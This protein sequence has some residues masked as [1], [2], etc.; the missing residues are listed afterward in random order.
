MTAPPP[1]RLTQRLSA[2]FVRTAEPGFYCDGHGLNL[3]VDP[4][5][6]R[7]AKFT[8]EWAD[9]AYEKSEA[10]ADSD[11]FDQP[12]VNS[13]GSSTGG[14]SMLNSSQILCQVAGSNRHGENHSTARGRPLPRTGGVWSMESPAQLV[15]FRRRKLSF[16][17][18]V[19]LPSFTDRLGSVSKLS[20]SI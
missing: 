15:S 13:L 16:A 3:R 9:A 11:D 18:V 5:G 14:Q 10:Q 19:Q 12:S 7:A 6:A 17:R 20:I 2:A 8:R 1:R 4:S